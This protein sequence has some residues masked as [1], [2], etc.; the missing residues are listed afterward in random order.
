MSN[1]SWKKGF[2][3]AFAG[4]FLFDEGMASTYKMNLGEK[5]GMQFLR[6]LYKTIDLVSKNIKEPLAICLFTILS[7]LIAT[8]VFYNIPAFV[9]LGKL[10]PSKFVRFLL[11]LYCELNLFA[12]G[13]CAFSR[14]NNEVLV[15]LW[16]AGR[17]VAVFPGDWKAKK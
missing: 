17:L 13:C 5:F 3:F 14:F 10:F 16:K 6:P 8:L 9:I 7:A 4:E 15:N 11:F 12:M 2:R 1:W